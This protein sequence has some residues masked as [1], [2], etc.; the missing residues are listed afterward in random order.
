L[1]AAALV[2]ALNVVILAAAAYELADAAGWIALGNVPGEG[3]TGEGVVI[4]AA[5]AAMLIGGIWAALLA[6]R[7]RD[8]SPRWPWVMLPLASAGFIVALYYA[9]DPYYAPGL[10]RASDGG[11]LSAAWIVCNCGAAVV[12]AA[13]AYRHDQIALRLMVPLLF[14]FAITA[15]FERAGH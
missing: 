7:A 13:L 6:M 12:V 4:V 14:F 3:P 10:R 11:L 8:P 1:R 5:L 15:L 2:F 9:Y